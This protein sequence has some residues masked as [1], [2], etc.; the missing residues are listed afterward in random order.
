MIVNC[1]PMKRE[2]TLGDSVQPTKSILG[3][4]DVDVHEI[5]FELCELSS[6]SNVSTCDVPDLFILCFSTARTEWCETIRNV[7]YP[8]IV[9]SFPD[10][11]LLLVDMQFN[12]DRAEGAVHR[13]MREQL[14]TDLKAFQCLTCSTRT[15]EGLNRVFEEAANAVL[16]KQGRPE[17]VF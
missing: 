14:R 1:P 10:V 12:V 11:P 5:S 7:W 2:S 6:E 9:S 13:S 8:T 3:Q 17:G 16:M 4:I 15:N